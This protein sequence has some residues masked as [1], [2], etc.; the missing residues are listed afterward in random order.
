MKLSLVHPPVRRVFAGVFLF[1]GCL[2][3]VPSGATA[4]PPAGFYEGT[5]HTYCPTFDYTDKIQFTVRADG[6]AYA[7]VPSRPGSFDSQGQAQDDGSLTGLSIR[8]QSTSRGLVTIAYTAQVSSGETVQG[9]GRSEDIL[10]D[11]RATRALHPGFFSGE[12]PLANGV[13]FLGYPSGGFFGYYSYA[14]YP[15]L[16]HFDLGFVYFLDA[17][18]GKGGAYLYDFKSNG[19]FFTGPQFPFPYLYDFSLNS[20]VFYFPDNKTTDHY[21]SNPRYF[22]NLTTGQV[23]SK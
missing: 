20:Q 14:Y 12:V 5:I 17:Q 11:V 19:W 2:L 23:F 15:Y 10:V 4:A 8:V 22:V 21:S 16:Y 7:T 9:S 18:D 13:Y 3:V 6:V 1:L